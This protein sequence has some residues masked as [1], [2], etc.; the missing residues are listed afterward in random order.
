[1]FLF[2]TVEDQCIP[3]G[4]ATVH[5]EWEEITANG[6]DSETIICTD[7]LSGLGVPLT[8]TY[9]SEGTH[10]ITCTVVGSNGMTH[11]DTF[12]FN[13]TGTDC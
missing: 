4:G 11:M 2:P 5:V 13:V 6:A 1:M 9:F 7:S 12:A 8:G 3:E 10:T